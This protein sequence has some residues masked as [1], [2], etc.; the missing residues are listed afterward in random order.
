MVTGNVGRFGNVYAVNL[1]LINVK[2]AKVENSVFRKV[3][4][5]EQEL[6]ED[7]AFAVRVLLGVAEGTA[8]S[9]TMTQPV[10]GAQPI[11]DQGA[12][13]TKIG[14][15]NDQI[16]RIRDSGVRITNDTVEACRRLIKR[17]FTPD[18]LVLFIAQGDMRSRDAQEIEQYVLFLTAGLPEK[19]F[20]RFFKRIRRQD[21]TQFYNNS[22]ESKAL[23]ALK[24]VAFG[25]GMGAGL[26]GIPFYAFSDS[27]TVTS[28]EKDRNIGVGLIVSGSLLVAGSIAMMIL[29]GVNI[30]NLPD[31]F[32]D[33][34]SKGEILKAVGRENILVQ[35]ASL[36]ATPFVDA[37]GRA[38][39]LFGVC[40]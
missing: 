25:I 6:L 29:D 35:G 4:G 24:W 27:D 28:P 14:F 37:E 16:Q 18:E 30:G 36:S 26:L 12:Q 23:G 32:F 8:P 7:F 10:Y 5:G 9:A 2:K 19:Q 34:A 15:N 20:E 31:R 17:K 38:G 33:K 13:L 39:L 21:L 1:K 22:T 3:K 11:V 40:F